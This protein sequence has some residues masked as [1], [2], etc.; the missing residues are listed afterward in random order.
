M[1]SIFLFSLGLLRKGISR[2]VLLNLMRVICVLFTNPPPKKQR[3]FGYVSVLQEESVEP[4]DGQQVVL[5][6]LRDWDL[7]C[8]V[9]AIIIYVMSTHGFAMTNRAGAD[10]RN[11]VIFCCDPSTQHPHRNNIITGTKPQ[12]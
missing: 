6:Q 4:S 8:V 11:D 12:N 2:C 10:E 3:P 1:F 5:N 9:I 7:W